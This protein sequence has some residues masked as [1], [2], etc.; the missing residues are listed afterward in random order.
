[1]YTTTMFHIEM[2][3]VFHISQTGFKK[4]PMHNCSK[5]QKGICACNEARSWSIC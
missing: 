1:M 3:R 5:A 2:I 4:L